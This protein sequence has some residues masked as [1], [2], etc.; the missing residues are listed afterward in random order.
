MKDFL[1]IL[2]KSEIHYFGNLEMRLEVCKRNA[3][4]Q[5]QRRGDALAISVILKHAVEPTISNSQAG[6]KKKRYSGTP[7]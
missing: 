5:K 6:N 1:V 3:K 7:L 2:Y 4:Q